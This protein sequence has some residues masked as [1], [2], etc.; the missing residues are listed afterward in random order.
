MT[1]RTKLLE[2]FFLNPR[3]HTRQR[4]Q[5]RGGTSLGSGMKAQAI[6]KLVISPKIG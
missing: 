5:N 2:H 4:H 1:D 6:I 3:K